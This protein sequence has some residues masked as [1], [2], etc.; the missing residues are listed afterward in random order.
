MF[1]EYL[2]IPLHLEHD[3]NPSH[4]KFDM[5]WFIVARDMAT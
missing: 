2:N 1:C 4:T 5:N 3:E